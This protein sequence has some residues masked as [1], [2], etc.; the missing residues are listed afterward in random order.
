MMHVVAAKSPAVLER[1]KEAY[2]GK[3]GN[4]ESAKPD[5]HSVTTLIL[6]QAWTASDAPGKATEANMEPLISM[7]MPRRLAK[8][9][10][11]SQRSKT[12][13]SSGV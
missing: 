9:H 10:V 6:M 12:K 5:T 11:E 3:A 1:M 13:Q 7:L 4:S 2:E 8:A